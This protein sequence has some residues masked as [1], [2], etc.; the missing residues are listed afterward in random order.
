MEKYIE[1]P[2]KKYGSEFKFNDFC[3]YTGLRIMLWNILKYALRL[4]TGAGK[5]H[6]FEKI[7]HYAQMAYTLKNQQNR[8]PPFFKEDTEGD[9]VVI[10]K[11]NKKE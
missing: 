5:E 6:D 3:H 9:Y 8:T 1:V 10:R 4:W 7:A 2:Q 11:I